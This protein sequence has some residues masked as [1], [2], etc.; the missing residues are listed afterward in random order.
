MH[1][2]SHCGAVSPHE[3]LSLDLLQRRVSRSG[4]PS[5]RVLTICMF[6]FQTRPPM[7]DVRP[8]AP[9]QMDVFGFTSS[10]V[11]VMLYKRPGY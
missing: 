7:N 10:M 1:V 3:A 9:K 5:G 11:Q 8:N 2:S 4:S 6:K